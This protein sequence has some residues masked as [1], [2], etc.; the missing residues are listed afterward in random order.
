LYAL[1]AGF[2]LVQCAKRG[3]PTGGPVDEK[4]PEI[5]REFPD[6]Y[7]T[8]FK[9]QTIKIVFDEYVKFEDLNKQLVISPPLK[10][11]PIITP[12][13]GTA[14]EIE[15]TITDT[16]QKNTTY[17]LNFGQSIVD[18]NEANP[19]PFYKY[20]FSTGNYVDSLTLKGKISNALEYKTADFVNVLLY[21]VDSTYTDSAIYKETPNYVL[22]TLDSLNTFSMENLREG[23]YRMVALKEENSDLRFDPKRDLIGYISDYVK[24]PS[25]NEYEIRL[26]KQIEDRDIKRPTHESKN[27]IHVGYTGS[28]EGLKIRAVDSSLIEK[29]RFT[30]LDKKDTLQYW[31]QPSKELDSILIEGTAS[32]FSKEFMVP[33]KDLKKD[34]LTISKYG[35]FKLRSNIHLSATTPMQIIDPSKLGLMDKDSTAVRFMTR[36]DSL[37]NILTVAFD[38]EENQRYLLTIYPDAVTDFFGFSNPDTLRLNYSTR[39]TRDYGNIFVTIENGDQFPV[40]V[41]V[42]TKDL[43]VV[44]EQVARSNDVYEFLLVDPDTYY[45][46]IVYDQN[47]NGKYDPGNYLLQQQPERVQYLKKEVRLQPNWDVNETISLK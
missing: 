38:K 20:V 42:V 39:S 7:S 17:V 4:A 47:N 32:K 14:R 41:Q 11:T 18:N 16:L 34:S 43:K 29:S 33:L 31:F 25:D 6:N 21:E 36:L 27:R 13:G 35:D 5:L 44:A 1:I 46:R 8:N 2:I 19:Y 23:T 9:N 28:I 30:K 45:L 10:T 24:V 3:N 37:K 40:I 22:N 15:I 26:Y 12:Q